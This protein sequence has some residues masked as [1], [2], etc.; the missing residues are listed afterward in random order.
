M[1]KVTELTKANEIK[2]EDILM[3]IQNGENKQIKASSLNIHK[4]TLT[5][6][7]DTE[8]RRRSRVTVLLQSRQ[9]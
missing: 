2:D 4:Y 1:K 8:K 5:V 3:I 7:S 9:Q 6:A